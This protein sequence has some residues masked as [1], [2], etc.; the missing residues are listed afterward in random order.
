M[1]TFRY[2]PHFR[3][4]I[5]GGNNPNLFTRQF[6]EGTVS[7][8]Q[9]TS[10]KLAMFSVRLLSL[11]LS[12]LTSFPMQELQQAIQTELQALYPDETAAFLRDHN[13]PGKPSS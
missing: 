10:G 12:L 2:S 6:L 1:L 4:H 8:A 3:S 11:L 7:D 9:L 5:D 13:L